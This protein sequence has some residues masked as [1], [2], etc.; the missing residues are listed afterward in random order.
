MMHQIKLFKNFL[1]YSFFFRNGR[2]QMKHIICM[3]KQI[4][5]NSTTYKQA[6]IFDLIRLLSLHI[7]TSNDLAIIS[8]KKALSFQPLHFPNDLFP[9]QWNLKINNKMLIDYMIEM[10]T[11]PNLTINLA[12]DPVIPEVWD[13]RRFMN[14]IT[15]IG[16][17]RNYLSNNKGDW[18]A[19]RN[20]H[21]LILL[22][23][24]GVSFVG[25][26]G[27][28]SINAGILQSQGVIPSEC[29]S[30][31]YDF[32]SLYDFLSCDGTYYFEKIT[33]KRL[34]KVTNFD[35]AAIYE[36]GRLIKD[37]SIHFKRS[38]LN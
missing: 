1:N 38:K 19:D 16:S 20:H 2:E 6:P 12:T 11:T 10:P 9:L 27:N 25:N 24:I 36:I 23:P 15:H 13:K 5:A 28:H 34:A 4:I 31:V 37:N 35:F 14:C 21:D 18:K 17:E 33:G 22:L 32:S 26:Y 8:G 3:A 29:I 7:L 30:N